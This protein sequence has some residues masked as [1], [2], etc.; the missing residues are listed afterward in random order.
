MGQL[1]QGVDEFLSISRVPAAH[2]AGAGISAEQ[3]VPVEQD[4]HASLGELDGSYDPAAQANAEHGPELPA[5]T[6]NPTPQLALQLVEG[7]ESKSG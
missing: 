7:F 4:V 1:V 5:G 6:A 2:V 3:Y